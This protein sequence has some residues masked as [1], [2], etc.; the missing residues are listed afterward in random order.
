MNKTYTDIDLNFE[1]NASGDISVIYD[2]DCVKQSLK[3]IIFTNIKE[4]SIYHIED[5]GSKINYYLGEKINKV[6]L[7]AIEDEIRNSIENYDERIE[8]IY[9]TSLQNNNQYEIK[10]QYKIK[11]MNLNDELTLTLGVL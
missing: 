10:I 9:I 6:I 8:L 1:A 4:Y 2:E 7:L 5:F 3:N 11:N